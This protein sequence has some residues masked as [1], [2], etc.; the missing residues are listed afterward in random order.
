MPGSGAIPSVVAIYLAADAGSQLK[1]VTQ[2]TAV[3]GRGLRGDRYF[4]G[5]GTFSQWPGTGRQITLIEI[6][7]LAALPSDCRIAPGAARRNLVTAGIAL[8]TLVGVEFRIGGAD[9]V[10]LRGQRPCD[11]CAHLERLTRAG[12]ARAL[13]GRGGL[14]AD[15]LGGGL[16]RVGDRLAILGP[17]GTD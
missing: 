13:V 1:S 12:I 10:V 15:V 6:E 9:G 17:A 14:R 8:A 2:A 5:N 16:I 11:P 7:V 4:A 3:A